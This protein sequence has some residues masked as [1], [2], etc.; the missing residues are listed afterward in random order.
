MEVVVNYGKKFIWEVVND[1]VVEDPT[2]HD[3]I[4]LCGFYFNLFD[5]DGKGVGKEWSSEFPY[6]LILIKLWTGNRKSQLNS[7]NQN[8]DEENGK[9]L[10]KGNGRYRKVCQFYS[11][12]LWKNIGCLV[13]APTFGLGGPRLWDKEEDIKTS[14]KNRNILSIRIKLVFMR[15]VYPKL[16]IV[17]Y[18]ILRLY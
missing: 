1:N 11:N 10:G 7:T 15:F 14:G 18:F 8:V 13:S 3:D 5:K 6:L 17:F 16:L 12:E 4:G 2:D 9:A